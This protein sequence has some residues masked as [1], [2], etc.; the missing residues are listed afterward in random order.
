MGTIT[1]HRRGYTRKDGTYVQPTT[2]E[3]EDRGKPGKTPESQRFYHPDVEMDW[4]KDKSAETRRSHA[5]KAH[6]GDKLATAR[7]LQALANV[8]TDKK[9]A[10]LAKKD[11]DYFF[12]KH[13]E[14]E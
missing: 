11:A 10:E 5:L 4:H 1:V 7:S 3:T 14:E 13:D 9:T 12:K 6:S 2:Y 8:T